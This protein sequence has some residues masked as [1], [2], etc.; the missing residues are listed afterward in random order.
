MAAQTTKRTDRIQFSV[1]FTTGEGVAGEGAYTAF[2]TAIDASVPTGIEI[3]SAEYFIHPDEIA[4]IVAA[5]DGITFGLTQIAS[6]L[7]K[8]GAGTVVSIPA[9]VIDFHHIDDTA[10]VFSGPIHLPFRRDFP[11][12]PLVH[13]ASLYLFQ[14]GESIVALGSLSAC[15]ITFR[16]VPLSDKEYQD[17]LQTIIAQNVI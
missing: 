17:I 10:A 2:K 5:K 16:Y 11:E 9:G 7:P 12:P 13:P 8:I 1:A 14:R 3:L 4:K 6:N 15:R